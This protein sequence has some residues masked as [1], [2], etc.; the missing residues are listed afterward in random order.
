[1]NEWIN[2]QGRHRAARAAKNYFCIQTNLWLNT[3]KTI[4]GK[5][6]AG[7]RWIHLSS[8]PFEKDIF[9]CEHSFWMCLGDV[10]VL[11]VKLWFPQESASVGFARFVSTWT[12]TTK[13]RWRKPDCH[14]AT[15]LQQWQKAKSKMPKWMEKQFNRWR[16]TKEMWSLL[17]VRS[18]LF[19]TP[20]IFKNF[21]I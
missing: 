12:L 13:Y 17:F 6:R 2:Y 14:L 19:S 11:F 20:C 3:N 8:Q 9:H 21:C 4:F 1:M 18:L 16:S 5:Q 15:V 7:L 10:L